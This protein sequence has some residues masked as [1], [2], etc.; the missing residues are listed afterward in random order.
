MPDKWRR[1]EVIFAGVIAIFTLVLGIVSYFQY[2]A[3]RKAAHRAMQANLIAKQALTRS[4]TTWRTTE[5]AYVTIGSKTGKLAE[6][7]NPTIGDKP[8][9]ILYFFNAGQS[10]ARHF[11]IHM[12]TSVWP[13]GAVFEHRHRFKGP[14][15][16]VFSFAM[17]RVAEVDIAGQTEHREYVSEDW[18]LWTKS[19]LASS[20]LP[21]PRFAL[22]GDFEYCDIFG[23]Y[24]CETFGLWYEPPP[25]GD[26]TTMFFKG[27]P[28]AIE[29]PD[30]LMLKGMKWP[31][32]KLTEIEACEQPDEAEHNYIGSPAR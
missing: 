17:S 7:G 10:T 6:L 21:E 4:E 20:K 28:C 19:K 1:A 25:V 27:Q 12:T 26:F 29:K 11:L 23:Q 3:A 8:I 13:E 31:V 9:I 14:D 22:W 16:Q 32:A 5:R 18:L 15:N 30:S 2:D 24:H